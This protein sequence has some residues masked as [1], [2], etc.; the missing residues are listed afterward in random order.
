MEPI[1]KH[2]ILVNLSV[3]GKINF[4]FLILN[5]ELEEKSDSNSK[6]NI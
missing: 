4:E 1:T 2:P 5:V 3:G 6:F